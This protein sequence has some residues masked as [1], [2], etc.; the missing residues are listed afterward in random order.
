MKRLNGPVS[1]GLAP[2]L[3]IA[4]DHGVCGR[5][6]ECRS[7]DDDRSLARQRRAGILERPVIEKILNH[8]PSQAH[9]Q[10]SAAPPQPRQL[11]VFKLS[12]RQS[13]RLTQ[14]E[15]TRQGD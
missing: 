3:C 11:C 2:A 1:A 10:R 6:N 15:S 7:S 8:L 13:D 12:C 14:D 4:D 9:Q 5:W